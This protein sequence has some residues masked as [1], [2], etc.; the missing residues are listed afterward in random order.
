LSKKII[1]L[2]RFNTLSNINFTFMLFSL[3][4]YIFILNYYKML[5]RYRI[6]ITDMT[7]VSYNIII[8]RVIA[9]TRDNEAHLLICISA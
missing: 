8:T 9:L 4:G 7:R 6:A 2:N 3:K 5:K 1:K